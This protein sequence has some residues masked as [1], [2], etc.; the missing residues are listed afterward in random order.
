MIF[1]RYGEPDWG[2]IYAGYLALG[3]T[4][5]LVAIGPDV[6]HYREPGRGR[7]VSIGA[8]LMLWFADLVSYLLPPPFDS[9]AINLS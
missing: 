2:P 3:S 1:D 7:G 4:L 9:F 5:V 8:F 6:E